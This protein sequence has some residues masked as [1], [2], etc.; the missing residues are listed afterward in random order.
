MAGRW[1]L[2]LALLSSMGEAR[3]RPDV[4]A[5]SAAIAACAAA[6]TP[7]VG[8]EWTWALHLLGDMELERVAPNEVTLGAAI[9]ALGR[10]GEWQKALDLVGGLGRRRLAPNTIIL[11]AAISACER[12]QQWETALNLLG[13][14]R[15]GASRAGAAGPAADQISFC[16]SIGACAS[17]RRW[18]MALALLREM[19]QG[20]AGAPPPGIQAFNAAIA[21]CEAGGAWQHALQLLNDMRRD[22]LQPDDVGFRSAMSACH[23]TSALRWERSLDLLG[24]LCQQGL[25]VAVLTCNFAATAC[26]RGLQWGLALGL[27]RTMRV[28]RLVPGVGTFAATASAC[29]RGLQWARTLAL[30]AEARKDGLEPGLVCFGAALSALEKGGRWHRALQLLHHLGSSSSLQPDLVSCNSAISACEKGGRWQWAIQLLLEEL[31]LLDTEGDA[32]S[33][34]SALGACRAGGEWRAAVLCLV[35]MRCQ[36]LGPDV[37][38][39]SALLAALEEGDA[40]D[41]S[42]LCGSAA[43][44]PALL[45]GLSRRLQQVEALELLQSAGR[46]EASSVAAFRAAAYAPSLLPALRRLRL[47]LCD[48]KLQGQQ[49]LPSNSLVARVSGGRRLHEPALEKYFSLGGPFTECAIADLGSTATLASWPLEA[50]AWQALWRSGSP[51]VAAQEPAAAAIATWVGTQFA[52]FAVASCNSVAGCIGG[53]LQALLRELAEAVH[54]SLEA[55]EAVATFHSN[56]QDL[57]LDAVAFAFLMHAP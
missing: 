50:R 42:A 22:G 9:S 38:T 56:L 51:E 54:E 24:E 29:D 34:N 6:E 4:V 53:A 2:A 21:A 20:S 3:F 8:A 41:S 26:A 5:Y 37:V 19:R 7:R 46:L 57:G 15:G 43:E 39:A 45:V 30:L 14:L 16:A 13:V 27:L 17:A 25:R 33:F 11:N 12:G 55:N 40:G 44:A 23:G 49:H 47:S 28:L 18:E 10:C 48:G 31:R 52:F 36:R 32:I 1:D 35:A